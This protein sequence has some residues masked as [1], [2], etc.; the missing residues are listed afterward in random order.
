MAFAIAEG[1]GALRGF[2]ERSVE[3]GSVLCTVGHDRRVQEIGGIERLANLT[4]A[5]IH[6]VGWCNHVCAGA[7]VGYRCLRE[8]LDGGIVKDASAFQQAAVAVRGVLA[9][10]DIRD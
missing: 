8:K 6:H 10:A 5:K 3:A 7:R 1:W 4:D 2:A 9:E